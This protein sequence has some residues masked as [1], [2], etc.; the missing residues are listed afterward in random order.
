MRAT[1]LQG[2]RHVTVENVPDP[3]LPGPSGVIVTV[4]RTAICGS[5]L[6]LYHDAPTGTGIQLGHEAI[7]TVT[8]LGPEVHSVRVGDRVLVSGVIGCGLCRPCLAGQPNPCLA[9]QAAAFGTLPTLPGGQSEGMAI[10]FADSFV[11][12]IPDGVS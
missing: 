4:E 1:V 6:H 9:G 7:G 8:E 12:P 3:V 10:P 11:R 2:P 5:D